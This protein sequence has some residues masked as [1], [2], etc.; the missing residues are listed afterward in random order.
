MAE[1]VSKH[2]AAAYQQA[3]DF[4]VVNVNG[5]LQK[6]G[7]N[8]ASYFC[9]PDGRVIHAVGGPVS[10]QKLL[11]EAQWTVSTYEQ[12]LAAA[13]DDRQ[14]QAMIVQEAHL[15]ELHASRADFEREIQQ[16]FVRARE[17]YANKLKERAKQ[18]RAWSR[19]YDRDHDLIAPELMARRWTAERFSGDKA[20]Q[21]LA[22]EPLAPLVQ[23]EERLFEKLTGEQFADNRGRIYSAAEGF[24]RAREKEMPVL[25]VLYK[26]RGKYKDEYDETTKRLLTEVLPR[27]P[28]SQPLQSYVV[29]TLPLNELA[30]LSNLADVPNYELPSG[31]TSQLIL[32]QPDGMQIE[33]ISGH[34]SAEHLTARLW[35]PIHEIFLARADR[36]ADEGNVSDAQRLLRR[37]LRNS[38]VESHRNRASRRIDELKIDMAETWAQQGR[39]AEA[40]RVF[41]YLH[42]ETTSADLRQLAARRLAELGATL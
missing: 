17:E 42:N 39:T 10:P 27:R 34:V 35:N 15:S 41:R 13:P 1:Y 3:G 7:G 28:V 32:A 4:T 18:G 25:L 37:V 24:Q 38:N 20:H 21:I 33:S 12:V 6:N 16:Q 22:A 8:V 23:V 30:A 36:Y 11:A 14:R 2:F 26:G 31:A 29:I 5:K 9:T 19:G 40:Q